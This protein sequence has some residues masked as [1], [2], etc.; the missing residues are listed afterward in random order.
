M[1]SMFKYK[2]T[3]SLAERKKRAEDAFL[4]SPG[5]IPVIIEKHVKSKIESDVE[6]KFAVKKEYDVAKL[7]NQ[8]TVRFSL[9]KDKTLFLF[10]NGKT[11]LTS[12]MKLE[13]VYQKYK[14]E[15]G[16]LYL[17]YSDT[18]SLGSVY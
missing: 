3:K 9:P 16:F 11:V 4:Q 2:A 14:D 18:A 15:D 17:M 10:A 8:L 1:S 13:E 6:S 5:R 7:I 12:N